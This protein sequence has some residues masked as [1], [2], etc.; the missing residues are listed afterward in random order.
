MNTWKLNER[1]EIIAHKMRL[2]GALSPLRIVC[3]CRAGSELGEHGRVQLR[4]GHFESIDDLPRFRKRQQCQYSL[5]SG[6]FRLPGHPM[7]DRGR[8]GNEGLESSRRQ[9]P[10]SP[11]LA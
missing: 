1:L 11:P 3:L 8:G 10:E 7:A 4:R 5:D 2:T 6:T 9:R